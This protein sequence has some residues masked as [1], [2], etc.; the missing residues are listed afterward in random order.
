MV[1]ASGP[2]KTN[3]FPDRIR[4][5]CQLRLAL[6]DTT[7]LQRYD[8]NKFGE[9][10]HA[11]PF[12]KCHFLRKRLPLPPLPHLRDVLGARG[13]TQ[14]L[15]R[16]PGKTGSAVRL[17]RVARRCAYLSACTA[18]HLSRE[19]RAD[20]GRLRRPSIVPPPRRTDLCC[21]PAEQ[22]EHTPVPRA[23][24]VQALPRNE[25]VGAAM[26]LLKQGAP[27]TLMVLRY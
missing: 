20:F 17:R 18:D 5:T 6:Y 19:N 22:H 15:R 1:R 26:R 11:P 24:Q 16:G 7:G 23:V 25:Q 9:S 3:T 10:R 4:M 21:S 27:R 12:F 8:H 13:G 14:R 2:C